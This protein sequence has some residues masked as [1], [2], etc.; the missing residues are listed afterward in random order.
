MLA[1]IFDS[2]TLTERLLPRRELL[3]EHWRQVNYTKTALDTLNTNYN[4]HLNNRIN[5]CS[6]RDGRSGVRNYPSRQKFYLCV[7]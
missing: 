2:E 4:G 1:D 3:T 5:G 7:C 6:P